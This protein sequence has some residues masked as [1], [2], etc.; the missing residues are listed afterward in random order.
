MSGSGYGQKVASPSQVVVV[1]DVD[2]DGVIELQLWPPSMTL[3]VSL[4]AVT[5]GDVVVGGNVVALVPLHYYMPDLAGMFDKL[6]GA[7]FTS[8]LDL[9]KGYWQAPLDPATKHIPRYCTLAR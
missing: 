8:C 7:A 1:G 4:S 6:K 9:E 2:A 5:T 3:A